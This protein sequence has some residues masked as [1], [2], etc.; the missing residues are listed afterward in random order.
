MSDSW[1]DK[2]IEETRGAL[3]DCFFAP[4]RFL[5]MKNINRN[6]GKI[7]RDDLIAEKWLIQD[8]TTDV[9]YLYTT[10]DEL[11]AAGWAID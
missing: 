5:H 8:K 11:I 1:S 2:L 6:F 10:I 7:H 4:D 3:H 9:E